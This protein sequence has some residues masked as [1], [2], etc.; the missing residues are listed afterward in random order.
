MSGDVEETDALRRGRAAFA[1]LRWEDAFNSLRAEDAVRSLSSSDLRLLAQS[2]SMT[3]RNA[4]AFGYRERA[5]ALSLSEGDE[6]GAATVAFWIGFR[7]GSIGERARSHAWL[8]RADDIASRSGDNVVSGYLQLPRIHHLLHVGDIASAYTAATSALATGDRLGDPDLSALARQ[9]AGRALL[10]N[11]DID[12][13]MRLLD[14]AMLLATTGP[15]SEL[16]K[17]LVYCAVVGCCQ[18][19]FAIDR[20]R[21]WSNVLDSWCRAQTQ[22]GIFDGT[23]RVH[24]AEILKLGGAWDDALA[25]AQHVADNGNSDRRER[26]AAHYEIGE[27]LRLRG[28]LAAATREY[29]RASELGG[30][31]QPGLA[32][33]RLAEGSIQVAV[34]SIGRSVATARDP[35][36][37]AAFLPAHVEILVAAEAVPE[38][39]AAAEELGDIAAAYDS[40]LLDALAAHATGAVA[41]ADARAED[42]L[43]SLRAALDLW[44]ELGATYA[45]ARTRSAIAAAFASL[46]DVD[47]ARLETEAA[48]SIFAELRAAEPVA[49]WPGTARPSPDGILTRRELQVLRLAATGE[50]NKAIGSA[51]GVSAR[52]IDRHMSAIL[53]KLA[54]PSR[55]GATAYAYEH[56]LISD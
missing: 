45:A 15:I 32:L 3:A 48:R 13:G 26:A 25:E 56:G 6:L 43:D 5:Y 33:L 19:V 47:G 2:A 55:A 44:D 10:E 12:G 20:A 30:E 51:L 4:D 8:S 29:E 42:A 11:G 40:P 38:A 23:C 17:G 50:T 14:E 21:E 35:L 36:T 34:G 54:V 9:L 24:R 27:I 16:S 37:R 22:L 49:A 7:L 1:A 28:D 46:G 53:L 41:L 39:A 52:T 18:R 31:P